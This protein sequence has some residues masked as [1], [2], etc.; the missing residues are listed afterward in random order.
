LP[1]SLRGLGSDD[2]PWSKVD[3]ALANAGYRPPPMVDA[4][5][6]TR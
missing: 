3:A 5:L 2:E 4:E 1:D 6:N